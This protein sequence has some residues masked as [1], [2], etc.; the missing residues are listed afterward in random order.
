MMPAASRVPFQVPFRW[1]AMTWS[2]WSSVILRIV[3]SRVM[4]ALLTMTSSAPN[5]VTAALTS[6]ST[7]SAFVTSH[8]T[9]RATSRA[10]ELLHGGVGGFGV[11]IAE[12]DARPFGDEALGDREADPLG[13]AG[14]HR[15]SSVKQWHECTCPSCVPA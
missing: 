4:P 10:A 13:P 3:A 14:D 9:A 1:T 7:S 8:R 15:G 2:N 6:A 12:H 5:S 11:E